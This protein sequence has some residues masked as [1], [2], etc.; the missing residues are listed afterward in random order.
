MMYLCFWL[1]LTGLFYTHVGYLLVMLVLAKWRSR[2]AVSTSPACEA[3]S[4]SVCVVVAA[5]N[6]EQ[7][8]RTRIGNIL[9]SD[10][11]ADLL[12]VVVVSDGSTDG[13]FNAVSSYPNPRVTAVRQELR[14]GKAVCLNEAMNRVAAEI[15]VFA[16]SRQDFAPDAI[17]VLVRAFQDPRVGAVSGSLGIR[18]AESTLGRGVDV[19]WRMEKKLRETESSFDSCIGCTGA[20]YAIRSRLFSEVPP[21]LIL[22]DV[23]IPM[24]IA[25]QGYRVLFEPGAVAWDNQSL[26]PQRERMRKRRTLAGNFQ[27]LT[28]FPTWLGPGKNRL[29][30]QL[31]SHKYLR[32]LG[33][34]FL[35]GLL[36]STIALRGETFYGI[37]LSGQVCFYGAALAGVLLSHKSRI[38]SIAS[39]F[40]FLNW[41]VIE[42]FWQFVVRNDSKG[43]DR[44]PAAAESSQAIQPDVRTLNR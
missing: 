14:S 4:V 12:S 5:H 42:G 36:A 20:I 9:A 15:T 13:T 43:W 30:W 31:L 41:M 34:L 33:P 29:W 32:L 40:V 39:G 26:E 37:M 18:S 27:M 35:V 2:S 3:N 38:T 8:I 11:P 16:D 7:R 1:S 6:E 22:D 10:Y 25:V 24:R 44:F 19:Y 21:G 17:R 28:L 23:V